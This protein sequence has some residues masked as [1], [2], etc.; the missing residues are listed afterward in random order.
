MTAPLLLDLAVLMVATADHMCPEVVTRPNARAQHLQRNDGGPRL[1]DFTDHGVLVRGLRPMCGQKARRWYRAPSS[2]CRPLCRR[3]ASAAER[4][5]TSRD[6]TREVAAQRLQA[7][8]IAAALRRATTTS[9]ISEAVQ[10]ACEAGLIAATVPA[11]GGPVLLTRLVRDARRRVTR[12]PAV[13]QRDRNWADRLN[14][15]GSRYPRR[16]R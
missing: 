3:C 4:F 7:A 16:Y 13:G 6:V 9:Q 14:P 2:D 1:R 15:P 10:L 8:D 11:P 5:A 12:P